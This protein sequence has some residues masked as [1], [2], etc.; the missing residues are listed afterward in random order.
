[1]DG[2]D[3]RQDSASPGNPRLPHAASHFCHH[4]E[5]AVARLTELKNLDREVGVRSGAEDVTAPNAGVAL[6]CAQ[7]KCCD[8][9]TSASA[10]RALPYFDAVV[11]P[12]DPGC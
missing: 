6:F 12:S 3:E 1:G 9:A 4:V 10:G 5:A 8:R 11:T 7:S 2:R